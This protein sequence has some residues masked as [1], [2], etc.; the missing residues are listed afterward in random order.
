MEQEK[1]G[2]L[3]L[4]SSIAPAKFTND[5]KG[6]IAENFL[7]AFE[8][9]TALHDLNNEQAAKIFPLFLGN[10]PL[11]WFTTLTDDEK[12][13]L[14]EMKTAILKVQAESYLTVISFWFVTK[15]RMSHSI[16]I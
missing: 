5:P 16:V 9:F 4:P 3:A 6:Q 11:T 15:N 1:I 13:S 10:E 8:K 2:A 14:E 7:L 12:I